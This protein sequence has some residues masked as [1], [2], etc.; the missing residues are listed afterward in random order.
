MK[1]PEFLAPYVDGTSPT[2]LLQGL[3]VGAVGAMAIGF[4][5]GGWNTGGTVEKKV[6]MASNSATVA[7]LAPICADKFEQAAKADGDLIVKLNAVS[8]WQRD[9]HL[10][11]DG[12]TTFA[13][14]A[15]PNRNV[16]KACLTMIETALKTE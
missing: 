14:G 8:S 1:T 13:G 12:W 16:A 5:L 3:V 4:G 7:A 11:D 9:D 10:A 2:R 6:E 15:E